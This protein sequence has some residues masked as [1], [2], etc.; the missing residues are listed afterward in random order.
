MIMPLACTL[1]DIKSK[2]H[3]SRV[4]RATFLIDGSHFYIS[5]LQFYHILCQDE[6]EQK[7]INGK[8]KTVKCRNIINLFFLKYG[9]QTVTF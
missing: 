3:V 5:V 2:D 9:N 4:H 8:S 6:E 7:M 1:R